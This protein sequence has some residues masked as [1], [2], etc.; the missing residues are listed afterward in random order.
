MNICI[1]VTEDNGLQSP[2]CAHFGSAPL[3][4][5]VDTESGSC[6]T[7]ANDNRN[8]AHG[9]CQPLAMLA[10]EKIDSIVVGGIGMGAYGK[11]KAANLEVFMSEHPTVDETVK[12]FRN[13]TLRPLNP[14]FLCGGH[15][16]EMRGPGDAAGCCGHGKQGP[17]RDQGGSGQ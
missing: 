17:H 4:M 10:G 5:I 13:G 11:L 2:V 6:R 9:M 8:H 16:H 3:F 1:P 15:A 7:I 14:A 12:A